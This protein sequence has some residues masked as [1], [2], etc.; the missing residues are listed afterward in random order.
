MATLARRLEEDGF[1]PEVLPLGGLFRTL[2][3][4]SV[5]ESASRLS[6]FL[7]SKTHDGERVAIVGHSLGGIIARYAVCCLGAWEH[8]HTVI[9]L[10]SPHRGSPVARVARVTPLRWISKSAVELTPQSDFMKRLRAAPIPPSIYFASFFSET[11]DMCPRPCAEIDVPA[12]ADNV[13]NISVGA[14]GHFELVADERV[15][16]MIKEELKR[17]IERSPPI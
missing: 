10:A 3:T 6:E 1:S 5:E 8:V 9:A 11:D 15:Y 16:R 4:K 13:V 12:E 7:R 17:G 14:C 2:N